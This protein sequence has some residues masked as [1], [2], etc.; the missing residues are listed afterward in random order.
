[1]NLRRGDVVLIRIQFQQSAGSKVRPAIV[2]IGD[3]DDDFV[4][5]PL[6]SRTSRSEFDL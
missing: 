1:M 2:I 6:T 4:A 3:G 5:A